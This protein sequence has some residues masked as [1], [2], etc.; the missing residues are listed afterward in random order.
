MP[1]SLKVAK[2]CGW[3][4]ASHWPLTLGQALCWD[5]GTKFADEGVGPLVAHIIGNILKKKVVQMFLQLFFH[6]SFKTPY[7]GSE[8]TTINSDNS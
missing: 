4:P 5:L 2:L 3:F 6:L 7:V 1:H 8:N